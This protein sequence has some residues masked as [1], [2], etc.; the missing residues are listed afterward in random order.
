MLGLGEGTTRGTTSKVASGHAAPAR[1]WIPVAGRA[2]WCR[3]ARQP[4]CFPMHFTMNASFIVT[5]L[6]TI[7]G[8]IALR[9]FWPQRRITTVGPGSV[10][11]HG[12][13]QDPGRAL[14]G[15]QECGSAPPGRTEHPGR[16]CR[17]PSAQPLHPPEQPHGQRHRNRAGHRGSGGHG[18]VNRR[19]IRCSSLYLG[20]SVGGTDRVSRLPGESMGPDDRH[21]RGPI[22]GTFA[23]RPTSRK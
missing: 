2:I 15:E 1:P 8:A 21:H 3:R 7:A 11:H 18:A 9:R 4:T 14:T 19:A 6:P 22:R 23:H 12:S 16:V 20:L 10:G 17:N 13:R 5:G